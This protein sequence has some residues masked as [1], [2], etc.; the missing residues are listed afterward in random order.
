MVYNI[1]L[2][3]ITNRTDYLKTISFIVQAFI[4][5]CPVSFPIH[6]AHEQ[7]KN[8]FIKLFFPKELCWRSHNIIFFPSILVCVSSMNTAATKLSV[9]NRK[10]CLKAASLPASL[11][12]NII[13]SHV[14]VICLYPD[15]RLRREGICLMSLG[16]FHFVVFSPL[17]KAVA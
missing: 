1:K 13:S 3:C 8:T 11:F 12:K 2:Y 7:K 5:M 14:D 9:I 6:R 16:F 4:L 17:N 15:R 10:R